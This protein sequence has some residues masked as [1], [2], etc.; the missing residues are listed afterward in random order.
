MGD[1]T[2]LGHVKQSLIQLQA[3][4]GR[5]PTAHIKGKNAGLVSQLLTYSQKAE[6]QRVTGTKTNTIVSN[7]IISDLILVDRDEDYVSVLLSQVNYM[8]IIDEIFNIKSGKS[9]D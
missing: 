1:E 8:G 5:I 2:G 6:T 4:I 7:G 9:C 3:L